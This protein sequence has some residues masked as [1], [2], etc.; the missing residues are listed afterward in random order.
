[1][2]YQLTFPMEN[3]S[4]ELLNTIDEQLIQNGFVK[5]G[6]TYLIAQSSK[7]KTCDAIKTKFKQIVQSAANRQSQPITINFT[8]L[9]EANE[10]RTEEYDDLIEDTITITPSLTH[11]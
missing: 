11:K 8:V 7:I 6:K 3:G 1:M 2:D 5:D 4:N 10:T 9:S